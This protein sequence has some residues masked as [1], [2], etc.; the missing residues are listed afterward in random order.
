MDETKE[1]IYKKFKECF[2]FGHPEFY[3]LLIK[4]AEIHEIKNKGYGMGNPF[5]N[6][7]ESTRIG[8]EPWKGC[9]I[10]MQDKVSRIYSLTNKMD[11]PEYKDAIKMESIEDTLLDLANYSLICLILLREAK[12]EPEARG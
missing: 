12:K 10:R 4:Q 11:N 1:E 3:E 8:I 5:G 7:M 9:L 2:K 6:F